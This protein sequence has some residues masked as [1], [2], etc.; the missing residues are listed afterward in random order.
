VDSGRTLV[1]LATPDGASISEIAW[2]PDGQRVV[3]AVD[4]GVLRFWDAAIG[5]LLCSLYILETDRD[6]LLVS[7]DGRLDGT[8]GAL[9]RL[10]AWRTGDG[11]GVN[12]ALTGRYRVR[13]L[14]T[15]LR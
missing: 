8:D 11:V 12:D 1:T 13:D 6:W 5:R 4:D 10:V 15:A 3:T 14:W 7:S 9:K 2:S